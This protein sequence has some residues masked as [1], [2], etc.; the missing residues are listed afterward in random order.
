MRRWSGQYLDAL[1][2]E[3][4]VLGERTLEMLDEEQPQEKFG[5]GQPSS[6]EFSLHVSGEEEQLIKVR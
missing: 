5:S 3:L 6:W 4:S 2:K 1:Y